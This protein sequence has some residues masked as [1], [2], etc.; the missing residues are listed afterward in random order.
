MKDSSILNLTDTMIR[1]NSCRSTGGGI[2]FSG[3]TISSLVRCRISHN[4]AG[5]GGGIAIHHSASP[6]FHECLVGSNLANSAGGVLL[7]DLCQASFITCSLEDNESVTNAGC[8]LATDLSGVKFVNSSLLRN[9]ALSGD[10][11]AFLLEDFT[12]PELIECLIQEN[13]AYNGGGIMATT[14]LE[15]DILNCTFFNNTATLN[16]GAMTF[17]EEATANIIGGLCDSN[18]AHSRGGCISIQGIAYPQISM[19]V[20]T[21]NSALVGGG[22]I[23][24]STRVKLSLSTSLL[25]GNRAVIGGGLFLEQAVL[26]SILSSQFADNLAVIG[27]AL[28]M[29]S[30]TVTMSDLLVTGNT[31]KNGGG[32]ALEGWAV[33]MTI[34][35]SVFQNNSASKSGGALYLVSDGFHSFNNSFSEFNKSAVEFNFQNIIFYK[36]VAHGFGGAVY[37][38]STHPPTQRNVSYD[39]NNAIEMGGGLFIAGEQPKTVSFNLEEDLVAHNCSPGYGSPPLSTS[40]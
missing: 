37:C 32:F 28:Y 6:T 38:D 15:V 24:A 26:G 40:K 35:N 19:T 14:Q 22:G 4:V 17:D 8:V 16:G 20:F 18:S 7:T 33:G 30:S 39:S 21:F 11:G 13:T 34:I 2:C 29:Q 9:K 10:G 5:K 36:N 31:A 27:G 1:W 25:K 3:S 23:Y 12:K